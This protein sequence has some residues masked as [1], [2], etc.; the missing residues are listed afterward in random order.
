M[1]T[2][3]AT[4][5]LAAL[6]Q[7]TR[8]D[9]Y[10]LLIRHAPE[11]LTAGE[12]ASALAVAPNTLSFHLRTLA[13]AGLVAAL[14]EGRYVRY[15]PCLAEIGGLVA[16]LTAECC[17]GTPGGASSCEVGNPPLS[18]CSSL[19]PSPFNVLFLCT[20]NSARSI[21]AEVLLASRGAA[22]GRSDGVTFHAYSAGSRPTGRVNPDALAFL[23]DRAMATGGLRSKSWDEFAAD[24]PDAPAIDLVITVCANAA[25]EACPI[26]PGAPAR[27]HWGQPDPAAVA[28]DDA[29]RRAAFAATWTTLSQRIDALLSLP[30]GSF[31]VGNRAELARQ[32]NRI[33]TEI[34]A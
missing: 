4:R 29:T 2:T 15:R 13:E 28:G 32:L 25:D 33:G 3:T 19:R 9:L 10:R 30:A 16:F 1:D 20:G 5:A 12:V 6:A 23:A 17:A 31:T 18:S 21:L 24:R 14:P 26:W 34:A 7:G 22:P 8:L 27:A 11:G